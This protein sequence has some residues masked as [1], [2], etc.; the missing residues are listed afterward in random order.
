MTQEQAEAIEK[1]G[2]DLLRIFPDAVEQD[3][4]A[5]CKKLRRIEVRASRYA[6]GLSNDYSSLS[7]EEQD[8]EEKQLL[9]EVI[10][11]LRPPMALRPYII[12]NLDPRGSALKIH[13]DCVAQQGLD[14]FRGW[15]G[16]GILA[17]EF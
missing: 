1:H 4:V 7:E 10:S 17:P 5:L 14:I 15:G 3:P 11:L 13:S 2:R 8:I 12:L 9:R 16:E 6:L